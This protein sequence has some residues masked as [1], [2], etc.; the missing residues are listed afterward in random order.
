MKKKIII[1]LLSTLILSCMTTPTGSISGSISGTITLDSN[2]TGNLGV[3]VFIA[4][5]SYMAMT[6]D[7]GTYT[8]SNV[9]VGTYTISNVPVGDYTIIATKTG[10]DD[11]TLSVSVLAGENSADNDL[12][13]NT[14]IN[15]TYTITFD[16]NDICAEGTMLPQSIA[17][18][19]SANLTANTFI[20]TGWTFAGWAT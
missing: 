2:P 20:K 19:S 8:I 10:F 9:P 5:T 6:D 15:L 11:N 16:A 14:T 18:G 17:S 3:L 12:N 1:L 4:S 7:T 13:L